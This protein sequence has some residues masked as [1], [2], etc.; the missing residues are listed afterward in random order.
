[1]G[2]LAGFGYA[3]WAERQTSYHSP[4]LH[5]NILKRCRIF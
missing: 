5:S 3:L 4:E 2:H 1:M